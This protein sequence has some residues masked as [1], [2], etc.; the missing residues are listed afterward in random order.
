[1]KSKVTELVLKQT[2]R[3]RTSDISV[4][5]SMKLSRI[6]KLELTYTKMRR[7]IWLQTP[8]ACCLGKGITSLS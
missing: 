6:T 3:T 7:L 5:V 2:L 4:G 8:T 1:M